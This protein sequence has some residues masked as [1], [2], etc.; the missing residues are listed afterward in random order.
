[1]NRPSAVL[2]A[3]S[4][5]RVRSPM[6]EALTKALVGFEIYVDSC[7]LK[8]EGEVD[9]FAVAVIDELGAD[10]SHHHAKTFDTLADGSFDVIITLSPDAHHRAL[11]SAR[12]RAVEV[13]YWP[14]PDPT[15]ATGSRDQVLDAY[16]AVRDLIARRIEAR[17]GTEPPPGG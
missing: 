10:L 11:E 6:A 13:E 8:S 7:G 2:F 5:N 4:Q 14:I 9:P 16:R 12:G 15:T 17:F 3:C 1:M